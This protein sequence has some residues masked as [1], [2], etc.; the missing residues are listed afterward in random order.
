MSEYISST[1]I[2]SPHTTCRIIQSFVTRFQ[3]PSH[4]DELMNKG[5]PVLICRA[6]GSNPADSA[7]VRR[8][9]RPALARISHPLPASKKE[10][11]EQ[12]AG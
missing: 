8:T 2:P 3:K 1:A 11:S 4:S 7:A 9:Y 10:C 5:K 6:V 12:N